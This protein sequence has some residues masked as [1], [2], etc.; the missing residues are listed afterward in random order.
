M[1]IGEDEAMERLRAA[2][3]EAGSQAA[4]ARRLGVTR[5]MLNGV[6]NGH[7]GLSDTVARGIGMRQVVMYEAVGD[8]ER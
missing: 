5:G 4:L 8:D 6:L 2:V 1:M 7:F 3:R